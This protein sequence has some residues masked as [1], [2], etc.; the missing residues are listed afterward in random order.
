[1]IRILTIFMV[2][3]LGMS[4]AHADEVL[5]AVAANFTAPM[6]KIAPLFEKD[7]GH[8][9][10]FSFGATGAF[11]AQIKN[12]GPYQVLLSAD[13]ETP[14]KLEQEGIAVPGTRFT[15]A[16]GRLVLWSKQAGFVD[17]KGDVMRSGKFQ[18]LALANPKLAPYGAAAIETINKLG[19]LK[20]LQ[21]KFVQGDNIAQTFQL[22][23]V[24]LSQVYADGKLTQ[25]SAWVV[26]SVF[27]KPIQQD[28]VMLVS[29]KN[30]PAALAFM[31]YL[32]SEKAKVVIQSFG[33]EN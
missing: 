32:K 18:R 24:A 23:F 22:G 1:M 8:Q 9:A 26:P 31:A 19:L 7:T 27:H 25:G 16:T 4:S 11:Y 14:F 33:Y 5:V 13:D 10:R 28:A 3:G 30:N 6:Q 20:D 2:L 17:S 15:Y 21:P 12:G 29:G